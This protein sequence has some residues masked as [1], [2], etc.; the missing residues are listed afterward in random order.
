[1]AGGLAEQNELLKG[2]VELL[3]ERLAAQGGEAAAVQ[4]L[5]NRLR[6]A[7]HA[8]RLAYEELKLVQQQQQQQGGA[9][10]H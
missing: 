5:Q 4:E 2:Q 6:A 8:A 3:K 9:G 7:K 10:P 1:M